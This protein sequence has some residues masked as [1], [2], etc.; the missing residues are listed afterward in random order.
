MAVHNILIKSVSSAAF[1][2]DGID[3]ALL[4]YE[5]VSWGTMEILIDN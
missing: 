1:I 4:F 2:P 5:L 3:A